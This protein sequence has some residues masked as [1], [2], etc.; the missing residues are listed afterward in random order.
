MHRGTNGLKVPKQNRA[1]F[2]A[3][4]SIFTANTFVYVYFC[5]HLI[6]V[7]FSVLSLVMVKIVVKYGD[8]PLPIS[9]SGELFLKLV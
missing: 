5:S 6:V 7:S 3:N 9:G 4:N 2:V 1:I 8:S